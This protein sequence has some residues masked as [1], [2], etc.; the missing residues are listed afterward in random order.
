MICSNGGGRARAATALAQLS[1]AQ[2]RRPVLS[3]TV[4]ALSRWGGGPI[5]EGRSN[6]RR[7][8]GGDQKL[9]S[10]GGDQK[11][12]SWGGDQLGWRSNKGDSLRAAV[13]RPTENKHEGLARSVRQA[14]YCRHRSAA[15]WDGQHQRDARRRR[16]PIAIRPRVPPS[17]LQQPHITAIRCGIPKRR[18]SHTDDR[19]LRQ[20]LA[21]LGDGTEPL[22]RRSS[23]MLG[24]KHNFCSRI[25]CRCWQVMGMGPREITD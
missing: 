25:L 7:L 22:R 17:N 1:A 16:S 14:G 24:I 18:L 23:S 13:D 10:W 5:K 21:W 9:G 20:R 2:A 6:I 8:E 15:R 12:G 11:L 3:V 4:T 19:R